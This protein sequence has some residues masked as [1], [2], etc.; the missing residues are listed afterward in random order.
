MVSHTG[1]VTLKHFRV[2]QPVREPDDHCHMTVLILIDFLYSWTAT[3][4]SFS[5]PRETRR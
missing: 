2:K 3:S 1:Y 4:I 5:F